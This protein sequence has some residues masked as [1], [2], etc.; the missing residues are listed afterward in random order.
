MIENMKTC[1]NAVLIA[2]NKHP[3]ALNTTL[4]NQ[5]FTYYIFF[6]R[7]KP[8]QITI[9]DQNSQKWDFQSIFLCFFQKTY[10]QQFSS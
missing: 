3:D 2:Q 6:Y 8:K 4:K 7:E 9:F 5:L 1:P 10:H